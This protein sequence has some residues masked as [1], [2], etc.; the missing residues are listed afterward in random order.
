MRIE[1]MLDFHVM[2]AVCSDVFTSQGDNAAGQLM[3]RKSDL[4]TKILHTDSSVVL[5]NRL[6]LLSCISIA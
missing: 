4:N 6:L 2:F 5:C 3:R 1:Y